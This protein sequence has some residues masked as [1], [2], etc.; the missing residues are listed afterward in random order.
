[1]EHNYVHCTAQIKLVLH[2]SLILALFVLLCTLSLFIKTPFLANFSLV[3]NYNAANIYNPKLKLY[4]DGLKFFVLM[5]G[6]ITHSM[7][8][9]GVLY[10][11]PFGKIAFLDS[12]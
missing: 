10:S 9:L 6:I 7:V 1:M 12:N 8:L 3:D 11:Q 4:F 5:C 2:H